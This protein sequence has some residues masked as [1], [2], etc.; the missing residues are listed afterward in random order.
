MSG[1]PAQLT[2]NELARCNR[3]GYC[4]ATCPTYRVLRDERRVARG[5]NE[6]VRQVHEGRMELG[7][8]L[9]GPLFDCLLCG[10]CTETC[11]GSVETAEL[12]VQA[13]SAWHA[14]HGQPLAQ[15]LIFSQLL[16]H[17]ERMAALMRGYALGKGTGLVDLAARLGILKFVSPAADVA[18]GLAPA[19]PRRFLRDRLPALGF[20]R[21]SAGGVTVWRLRPGA[22]APVGP[23]VAYFIGCGTNYQ[24]PQPGAAAMRV[25]AL[26]GCQVLVLPNVCCGMPPYAYGDLEAARGLVRQNLRALAA[27]PFDFAVSECASCSGFLKRWPGLLEG[28]PEA[29]EAVALLPRVRDLTELLAELPLPAAPP[30]GISVTYHQPCH[31]GR[32]QGVREQPRRL[33]RDAGGYELRELPEAEWCCGGAGSYSLTHPEIAQEVLARKMGRVSQT[34][35]EVLATS[36]AG[37]MV[38]L[39]HGVRQHAPGVRLLSLPE[40]LARAYQIVPEP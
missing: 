32:G 21:E 40:L 13:R 35:A 14:A 16:P 27:V 31:L 34:G 8:D 36:C 18:N 22:G 29:P 3:C 11:F 28:Q 5:R 19:A 30:Q 37:C 2:E 12:L 4:M 15:R 38:Q 9:R 20:Q 6:L 33:L 25:L 1:L 26:A 17:P 23:T 39:G 7:E 10:A 24:V